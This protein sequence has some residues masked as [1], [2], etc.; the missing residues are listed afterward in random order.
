MP[1]PP[2]PPSSSSAPSPPSSSSSQ[3]GVALVGTGNIALLHTLGYRDNPHATLR[4]LCDLNARRARKFRAECNLPAGIPVYDDPTACFRA[5]D[6]DLVE[7]LTPHATHEPLAVAAAEAGKHVSVQKPPAMTLASYDRMVAAARKAGVRFRV[8]ENFRYHPPYARAFELVRAGVVGTVEAVNVRMWESARAVGE[9]RGSKKRFPLH[10][11]KWKVR[12][13]HN[14]NAPNLWDDGY[15]KHSVVQGFLGDTPDATEPVTAV[16]A[17]CGWQRLFNVYKLDVPAVVVYETGR[18]ARYGTWNL[19]MGKAIP[20][21]SSY[22]ACDES[23]EV[24]GSEGIVVAPGCTGNLFV[25]CD[26]GGPGRPGVYWFSKDDADPEPDADTAPH[27]DGRAGQEADTDSLAIASASTGASVTPA[28]SR[29]ARAHPDAGTWKADLTMPTDWQWSFV[30]C[31]RH[32][33]EVLA[34]DAWFDPRDPRFLDA[35]RGRQVL[36]IGLAIIESLR[37]D[38]ARVPLDAVPG[39]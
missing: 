37:Q 17:W 39:Y 20:F 15:H 23:L 31:T 4:A 5:D 26:C 8:Y 6:V 13:K 22:F 30:E 14:Y 28:D 25:G 16:R 36:A 12:K 19:S 3:I 2:V 9:Y 33:A 10:T 18:R 32:L 34:R 7:I 21:H 1:A 38:G 27:I 35:D 29:R 24:S 11:L